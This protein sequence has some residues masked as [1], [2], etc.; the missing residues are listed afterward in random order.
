MM[1]TAPSPASMAN[2]KKTNTRHS[3]MSRMNGSSQD[4]VS[5]TVASATVCG[6]GNMRGPATRDPAYQAATMSSSESSLTTTSAPRS[7]A[8]ERSGV[9]LAR[10]A[11]QL[12]AA[13]LGEHAVE[14]ARVG[15]LLGE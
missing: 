1:Y 11:D 14:R 10:R 7:Q 2:V 6:S 15:L 13:D 5:C 8:V 9:E 4:W 3:V 12:G